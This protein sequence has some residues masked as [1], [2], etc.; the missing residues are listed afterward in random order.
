LLSLYCSLL[1][2]QYREMGNLTSADWRENATTKHLFPIENSQFRPWTTEENILHNNVIINNII[3]PY[4][5]KELNGYF[6]YISSAVTPYGGTLPPF[7]LNKN[8]S[9][10]RVNVPDWYSKDVLTINKRDPKLVGENIHDNL[11]LL[12]P[13]I[14]DIPARSRSIVNKITA[15]PHHPSYFFHGNH[16]WGIFSFPVKNGYCNTLCLR[17]TGSGASYLNKETREALQLNSSNSV[18]YSAGKM[19]GDAWRI[20]FY[21]QTHPFFRSEDSGNASAFNVNVV[22]NFATTKW[23]E[24]YYEDVARTVINPSRLQVI[25]AMKIGMGTKVVLG[26]IVLFATY[27]AGVHA[28]QRI[29]SML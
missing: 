6:I 11:V 28:P 9:I 5:P 21:E 12:I 19:N 27:Y 22:G 2:L 10:S 14:H 17:D 24:M 20:N 8:V 3:Q 13:A 18:Y 25:Q 29:R 26:G 16:W 4:L 7:D 23:L 15:R 1:L